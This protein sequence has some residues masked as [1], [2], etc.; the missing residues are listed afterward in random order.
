MNIAI[1]PA[2]AGSKRLKNKNLK[3]INGKPL[4]YYAIKTAIKSKLFDE[5]IIST[6]SLKI[7]NKAGKF[8]AKNNGLRPKKLSDNLTLLPDVVKYEIQK[9]EKKKLIKNVCCILPT[10]LYNNKK[11]LTLGLKKLYN[12]S[13][14][15]I[16]CATK[17]S[18]SV[19]RCFTKGKNQ[20]IKMIFPKMFNKGSHL[21]KDT[22]FDFGNFYWAKKITWLNKKIFF[23]K[24]SKFIEISNKYYSDI[25]TLEDFKIA[26]TILKKTN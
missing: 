18:T 12:N 6:D 20:E 25:N 3:L 13:D 23:S 17:T 14:G 21:L 22:Y 5:V 16:F 15:Y 10:N 24:N 4:I 7:L 9:H 8:G 26:K 11:L 2:R 1:I 19:F